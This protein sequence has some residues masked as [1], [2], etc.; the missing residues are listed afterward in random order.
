M[1]MSKLINKTTKYSIVFGQILLITLA[2]V[3][4][5]VVI[6][7]SKASAQ[8]NDGYDDG[9]DHFGYK[10]PNPIPVVA[11]INP[12]SAN[13]GDNVTSITI[14]G[15]GFTPSSVARWNGSNRRTT[16]I[17]RQHLMI[18]LNPG[19][20]QGSS[21]QYINVYNPNRNEYSNSA[22]FKIRGYS[23]SNAGTATN[24]NGNGNSGSTNNGNV[25]TSYNNGSN[26]NNG[27]S[28]NYNN[29]LFSYTNTG[30]TTRSTNGNYYSNENQ[31]ETNGNGQSA[32]ALASGVIFGSNS[33][34]P[35]GI[36]QWV[37]FA[38]AILLIV[39]I[40]RKFFGGSDRY[41]NSPLKHA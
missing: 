32:S 24:N 8:Y 12:S 35:S 20:L 1:G 3:A 23:P 11:G 31:N 2:L 14:G 34:A 29:S 10:S 19:D 39:I 37:L 22:F 7:P 5:I 41:H 15:N 28:S 25:N 17:D 36:I 16:F 27:G 38:I 9:Y 21:G 13:V 40:V 4:L 26:G 33:L 18:H 6:M 30:D